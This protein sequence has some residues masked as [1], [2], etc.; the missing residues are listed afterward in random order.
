METWKLLE[1]W[2]LEKRPKTTLIHYRKARNS[3]EENILEIGRYDVVIDKT[4]VKI[5]LRVDQNFSKI[6]WVNLDLCDPDFFAKFGKSLNV[7]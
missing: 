2:V 4:A 3:A 6:K 5:A 7:L 1:E